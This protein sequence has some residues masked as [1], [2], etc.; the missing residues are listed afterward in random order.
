MRGNIRKEDW[1]GGN[2]LRGF[3]FREPCRVEVLKE[4]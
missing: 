3:V 4:A 1:E 2:R